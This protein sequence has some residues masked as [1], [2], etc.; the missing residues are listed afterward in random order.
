MSNR[1]KITRFFSAVIVLAMAFGV[2]FANYNTAAFAEENGADGYKTGD[3]ITLGTMP[4][5]SDYL[6]DGGACVDGRQPDLTV[7]PA[8]IN[9][10]TDGMP[11]S[12]QIVDVVD[13]D[14]VILLATDVVAS[15]WNITNFAH[16]RN[17]DTDFWKNSNIRKFLNGGVYEFTFEEW[18]VTYWVP[19]YT[20]YTLDHM[21]G[22]FGKAFT[23]DE[24]ALLLDYD[25][26]GADDLNSTA[27]KIV[28]PSVIEL[29][30]WKT[31]PGVDFKTG[32]IGNTGNIRWHTRTPS[33]ATP[34]VSMYIVD[35]AGY[36]G[37]NNYNGL[38]HFQENL[39]PRPAIMLPIGYFEG[40]VTISEPGG[41]D[42]PGKPDAELGFASEY[43]WDGEAVD[44]S[45]RL[46]KDDPR[47]V[48][49]DDFSD[50]NGDASTH[51]KGNYS[52]EPKRWIGSAAI[53]LDP[54][55]KYSGD[56]GL[57]IPV[58]RSSNAFGNSVQMSLIQGRFAA[59]R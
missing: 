20:G 44:G 23:E 41:T 6:P 50:Y 28:V 35:V 5:F 19:G 25:Y 12:W 59:S 33:S 26:T 43:D 16:G 57:K 52:T 21:G 2:Y 36:V 4:G 30:K 29:E 32:L 31:V 51:I 34:N 58:I 49:F 13:G 45:G 1:K 54:D 8:G 39:G 48:M 55:E 37:E 47:I 22:F 14:K 11:I 7:T 27:D 9:E 18:G 42:D 24:R 15:M 53:T 40:G 17:N 46:M 38:D 3:I 56:Y 10:K